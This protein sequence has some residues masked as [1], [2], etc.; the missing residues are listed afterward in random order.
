M[1]RMRGG[2]SQIMLPTR[3]EGHG[4]CI[5]MFHI[6]TINAVFPTAPSPMI[7]TCKNPTKSELPY[8]AFVLVKVMWQFQN[9]DFA[10]HITTDRSLFSVPKKI[11][12][13]NKCKNRK[14]VK[15]EKYNK[16]NASQKYSHFQN[17]AV[18][19]FP[20]HFVLECHR[21]SPPSTDWVCRYQEFGWKVA[22]FSSVTHM[23]TYVCDRLEFFGNNRLSSK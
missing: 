21:L 2:L 23:F 9:V 3:G 18:R 16:W 7:T 15:I 10:E 8:L 20:L 17:F 11:E 19:S 5:F 4:S 6:D 14:N 22:S 12:N 13:S 1:M